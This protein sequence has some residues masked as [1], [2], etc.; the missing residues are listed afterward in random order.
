VKNPGI[1]ACLPSVWILLSYEENASVWQ[2]SQIVKHTLTT[3]IFHTV[4]SFYSKETIRFMA[5]K[6]CPQCGENTFFETPTGRECTK[7][8][9]TM[10]LPANDGKGGQGKRCSHC[11][12]NKVFNG[13]CRNCGAQYF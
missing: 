2:C 9:Y 11:G 10:I 7:C 1:V 5:G 4:P 3:L 8:K 13:K 12:E 6:K